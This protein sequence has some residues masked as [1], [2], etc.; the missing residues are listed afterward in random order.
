MLYSCI[1][2]YAFTVMEILKVKK[3]K[4]EKGRMLSLRAVAARGVAI[5][6]RF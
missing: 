6:S 2:I 3:E 4:V 5:L 1:Y